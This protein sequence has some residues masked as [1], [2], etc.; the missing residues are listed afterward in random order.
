MGI[1]KEVEEIS[2][3][4]QTEVSPA[5]YHDLLMFIYRRYI[6]PHYHN[7]ANVRRWIIDGKET[8]AFTVL[9]QGPWYVDVEITT[10]D[11]FEIKMR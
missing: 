1:L 8:L 10:G 3:K 4:V 7:F 2:F 11:P 5:F 9:G 6:V